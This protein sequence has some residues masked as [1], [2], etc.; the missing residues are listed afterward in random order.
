MA[1][2]FTR[3]KR[4]E[5]MAAIRAKNTKP[6]LVVRR[7]LHS[8]GFRFRLHVPG[9]PGRPDIVIPKVRTIV[10]VKGCFWHGHKCLRGRIPAKNRPYWGPKI[11]GNKERD[12][13]NEGRLRAMGWSVKTIW[14]CRIR[15]SSAGEL[16]GYLQSLVMNR[17]QMRCQ[18]FEPRR[19]RLASLE[20]ALSEMRMRRHR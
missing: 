11:T 13:R 1:D 15:R 7:L 10:Q 18:F 12:R 8:M 3:K 9:L 19:S 5:V 2:V 16:Y 4:S 14:E 20:A 17:A 6:E